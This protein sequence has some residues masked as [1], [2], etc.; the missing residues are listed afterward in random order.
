MARTTTTEY[1]CDICGKPWTKIKEMS[2][3]LPGLMDNGI[4]FAPS[5]TGTPPDYCAEC[6]DAVRVARD[7]VI[8]ERRKLNVHA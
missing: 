5:F 8:E 6:V 3:E 4:A 2:H 1:I 7:R